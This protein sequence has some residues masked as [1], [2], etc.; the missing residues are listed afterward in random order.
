MGEKGHVKRFPWLYC[1]DIIKTH[2]NA[3]LLRDPLSTGGTKTNTHFFQIIKLNTPT[4]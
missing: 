2:K 1:G 4:Y 3:I